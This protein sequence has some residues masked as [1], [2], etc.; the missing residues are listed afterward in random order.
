MEEE[1]G[2]AVLADAI[3][4]AVGYQDYINK[5]TFERKPGDVLFL[6]G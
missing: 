3:M 1:H 6:T 5:M 2:Q 4:K